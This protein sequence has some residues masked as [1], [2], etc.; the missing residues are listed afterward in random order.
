MLN[1]LA[2]ANMALERIADIS[3]TALDPELTREQ[4]VARVKAIYEV[5]VIGEHDEDEDIEIGS[6][7]D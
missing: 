5:S 7:S 2:Q 6:D 3:V 1:D 4:V